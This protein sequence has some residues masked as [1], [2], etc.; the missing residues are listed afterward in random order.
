MSKSSLLKLCA[1]AVN[2][3]ENSS[4]R[5]RIVVASND[6]L[7]PTAASILLLAR[8]NSVRIVFDNQKLIHF[9]YSSMLSLVRPRIIDM[10]ARN[11]NAYEAMAVMSGIINDIFATRNL[12]V[13]EIFLLSAI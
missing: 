5:N 11:G 10:K 2:A 6:A 8:D 13:F 9:S 12:V 3:E 4:R 1:S 7:R